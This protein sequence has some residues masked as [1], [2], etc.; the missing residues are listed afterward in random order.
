[1]SP[2]FSV[3]AVLPLRTKLNIY[4]LTL[5]R[6]CTLDKVKRGNWTRSHEHSL[7]YSI[8]SPLKRVDWR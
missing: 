6:V 3:A 4:Y 5:P 8:G 1:M 7:Y 2:R